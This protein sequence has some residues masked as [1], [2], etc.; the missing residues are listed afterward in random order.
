MG[1]SP[2]VSEKIAML[3]EDGDE[4]LNEPAAKTSEDTSGANA[5]AD[6]IP[7]D[8]HPSQCVCA[9]MAWRGSGELALEPVS[10][11]LRRC[12]AQ[13]RAFARAVDIEDFYCVLESAI[14]PDATKARR[15]VHQGTEAGLGTGID[16][17]VCPDVKRHAVWC[18]LSLTVIHDGIRRPKLQHKRGVSALE[19][20]GRMRREAVKTCPSIRRV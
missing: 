2:F 16:T 8:K 6:T 17:P 11:L 7:A 1:T 19:R 9:L 20:A 15:Y 12:R 4:G 5:K 10:A 13:P 14:K 18:N 3:D